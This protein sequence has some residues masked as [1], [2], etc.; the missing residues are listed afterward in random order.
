MIRTTEDNVTIIGPNAIVKYSPTLSS[1]AATKDK[2]HNNGV[3][4]KLICNPSN[5][6]ILPL[7]LYPGVKAEKVR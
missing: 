3:I 7:D 5:V 1:L 6:F 4:R 2:L